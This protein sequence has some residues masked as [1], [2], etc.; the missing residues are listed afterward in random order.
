MSEML[1]SIA[2]SLIALSPVQDEEILHPGT[3]PHKRAVV[4]ADGKAR[5]FFNQGLNFMYAF[6]HGE[7]KRSFRAAIKYDPTSAMAYWG[8]AM[9]NGPHI[10]NMAVEPSEEK[11]AVESLKM[12]RSLVSKARPVD[13]ALIRATLV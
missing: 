10:N 3:G 1:L 8:L 4:I 13:Q 11:E 2:L 5:D 9:A 7:A 6:N 12:A